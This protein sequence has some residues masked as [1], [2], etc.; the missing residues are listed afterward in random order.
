MV[1][2]TLFWFGREQ[3]A[4]IYLVALRWWR[5]ISEGSIAGAGWEEADRKSK[6]IAE[7]KKLELFEGSDP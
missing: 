7:G 4:G 2:Q 1:G 6:E 3:A 5:A